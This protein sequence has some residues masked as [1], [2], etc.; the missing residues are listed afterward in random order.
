MLRSLRHD[1]ERAKAAALADQRERF[2]ANL[3]DAAGRE[4]T[5]REE[6]DILIGQQQQQVEQMQVCTQIK[7]LLTCSAFCLPWAVV[8]VIG[9]EIKIRSMTVCLITSTRQISHKYQ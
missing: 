9:R 3:A 4:R 1:A 5:L 2:E 6:R 7:G 8:S